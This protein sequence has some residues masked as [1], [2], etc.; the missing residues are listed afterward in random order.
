M[1]RSVVQLHLDGELLSGGNRGQRILP[2]RGWSIRARRRN[3]RGLQRKIQRQIECSPGLR[4]FL[5]QTGQQA[6][7]LLAIRELLSRRLSESITDNSGAAALPGSLSAAS[8]CFGHAVLNLGQ[9][10]RSGRA[11]SGTQALPTGIDPVKEIFLVAIFIRWPAAKPSPPACN[12]Y[13]DHQ[14]RPT[15]RP[16]PAKADAAILPWRTGCKTSQQADSPARYSA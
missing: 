11:E 4:R 7:L 2:G 6:L 14:A 8:R 3:Q 16:P 1:R 13:S 12:R 9:V 5:L 10:F 15:S